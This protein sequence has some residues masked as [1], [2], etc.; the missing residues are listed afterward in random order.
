M[1]A[2]V[3]TVTVES[4]LR[5]EQWQLLAHNVRVTTVPTVLVGTLFAGIYGYRYGLPIAALWWLLLVICV[6]VRH[7]MTRRAAAPDTAFY[8]SMLAYGV[9]WALAPLLV[10]WYHEEIA[11]GALILAAGI[12]V[13]AFGSYGID[14]RATAAVAAPIGIVAMLLA[15][16]GDTPAHYA[17][18]LALPLLFAHQFIIAGQARR[19]LEN[20]IRLRLENDVLVAQLS[21][22]AERTATELE[23]RTKAERVLRASRDRAERLS[24]TDALT[25]IANRRYFDKRLKAEV[26]RAFRD[27]TNLA[28]VICDIDYFKQFND[29]YGHQR[30]DECLK[31]FAR[32]LVAFCRRGGDVAARIGGEEFALILPNTE[33]A[34]AVQLAEQA[35]AA[36]DALGIEHRGAVGYEHAT[37]SFGVAST[38]PTSA[39][40]GDALLGAADRALYQAKASG[41]NCV[42]S[43]GE[44]D[45]GMPAVT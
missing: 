11:I 14:A 23:R 9:L 26:S 21:E 39:E 45:V 24:G 3:P 30:G 10:D 33:H 8:V 22:R 27:R 15:V 36:F 28:L 43:A 31:I 40:A 34:A 5:A 12:G 2:V 29:C 41:R 38:V 44:E 7:M 19:V 35:R 13:A 6:A 4:A 1:S 18:A 32:T 25:E 17:V 42:R 20:Q 16:T 37:A